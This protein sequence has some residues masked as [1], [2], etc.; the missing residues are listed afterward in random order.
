MVYGNAR[1]YNTYWEDGDDMVRRVDAVLK[2]FKSI[3]NII[4]DGENQLNLQYFL[5]EGG[6]TPGFDTTVWHQVKAFLKSMRSTKFT[7]EIFEFRNVSPAALHI[8]DLDL[9]FQI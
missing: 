9:H 3:T 5:R 2:T 6:E 4:I 7:C 8:T 1:W